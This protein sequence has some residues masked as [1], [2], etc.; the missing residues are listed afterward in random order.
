MTD[1]VARFRR[2][3]QQLAAKDLGWTLHHAPPHLRW[4]RRFGHPRGAALDHLL[5]ADYRAFVAAAGYPAIGFCYYDREGFSMLPPEAMAAISVDLPDPDD[6]WPTPSDDGPTRCLYAFFAGYE[7]SDIE[8]FAFGP[9]AGGGAPVVW[10][11]EGGMPREEVGT[12]TAWLT[13]ELDR[14]AAKIE[15]LEAADVA[16]LCADNDGE[17]D[18]HRVI[19]YSLDK[20]Y[21]V[22]PY[23]AADLELAWVEHQ[24]GSPYSYGLID[25]AGTWRIPLG[26]RFKSVR[27]FRDGVAEVILEAKGATYSGPWTKIRLDGSVVD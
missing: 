12:F 24:S 8:G 1:L 4:A 22:P 11:V 5:P 3:E 21:D 14:L 17:T 9:P 6:T 13:A 20:T 25:A 7:L 18:P 26:K 10:R 23:S 15:P 19:D 27:P 16:A 2:F